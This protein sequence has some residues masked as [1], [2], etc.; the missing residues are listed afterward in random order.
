VVSFLLAS[1]A[2]TVLLL[3]RIVWVIL[4]FCFSI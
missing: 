4:D 1:W 2:S 3:F